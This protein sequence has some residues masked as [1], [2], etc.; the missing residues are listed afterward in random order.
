MNK[1]LKFKIAIDILMT[2]CWIITMFYKLT[3]NA[4]HEYV[5]MALFFLFI[6]HTLLNWRWYAALG[7]GTYNK[8]RIIRTVINLALLVCVIA[9]FATVP[10]ISRT[11][12]TGITA[13]M[14]RVARRPWQGL[15]KLAGK[16]GFALMGIHILQHWVLLKNIFGKSKK[17]AS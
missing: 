14:D 11:V 12:Y 4:L 8:A 13:G 6:L 7:K 15:H 10:F 16:A 17:L 2:I 5:G 9:T 3:G 1:T